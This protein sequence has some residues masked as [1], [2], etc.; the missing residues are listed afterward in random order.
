M[1]GEWWRWSAIAAVFFGLIASAG[2]EESVGVSRAVELPSFP[3][4]NCV[5]QVIE[6]NARVLKF[7]EW[8]WP[9]PGSD[10]EAVVRSSRAH[11]FA[12]SGRLARVQ[13]GIFED[14]P[15]RVRWVQAF[16]RIDAPMSQ[17]EAD[18]A[19]KLMKAVELLVARECD[20]PVLE[21]VR[22]SCSGVE[23]E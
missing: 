6:S 12:Y 7:D 9:K 4:P 14:T 1:A 13:L 21:R 11:H 15:D 10:P 23:C 17:Q 18:E 22:E 5:R 8:S 19:R 3:D 2:C 20:Q 16:I